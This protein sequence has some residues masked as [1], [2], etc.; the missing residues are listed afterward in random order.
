M[1][2]TDAVDV[3]LKIHFEDF[4]VIDV[5]HFVHNLHAV[6]QIRLQL[7]TDLPCFLYNQD[8]YSH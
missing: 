2:I 7:D 5:I 6:D 4:L 3:I 8:V 1:L